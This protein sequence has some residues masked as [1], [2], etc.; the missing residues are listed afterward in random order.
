[1]ADL[2]EA[3]DVVEGGAEGVLDGLPCIEE[4]AH[5]RQQVQEYLPNSGCRGLDTDA[6]GQ[7]SA[8][9]VSLIPDWVAH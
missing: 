2:G 4:V 6:Q 5:G 1:V 8:Q 7:I 9:A 3:A